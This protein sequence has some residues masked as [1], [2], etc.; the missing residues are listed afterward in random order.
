MMDHLH[1]FPI[2]QLPPETRRRQDG[3]TVPG[4][5]NE[6]IVVAADENLS[7][8]GKTESKKF[9]I[10]HISAETNGQIQFH[11]GYSNIRRP[12]VDDANKLHAVTEV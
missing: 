12:R 11:P 4:V 3:D 2:L 1:V 7:T 10:L 6:Q 8:S 5:E 9:F